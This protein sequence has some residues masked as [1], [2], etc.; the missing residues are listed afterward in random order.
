MVQD[1]EENRSIQVEKVKKVV[2]NVEDRIVKQVVNIVPVLVHDV[3]IVQEPPLNISFEVTG[4]I[5]QRDKGNYDR[6]I[7]VVVQDLVK[8]VL[9]VQIPNSNFQL[10]KV[11]RRKEED[12]QDLNLQR[13]V[14]LLGKIQ[15]GKV[16]Y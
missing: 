5:L 10:L 6:N 7:V 4:I 8:V 14:F 3:K 9:I 12:F 1:G 13:V 15:V 16:V 11:K 2:L